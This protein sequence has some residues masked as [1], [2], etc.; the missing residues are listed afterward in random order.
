MRAWHL[1]PLVFCVFCESN[2]VPAPARTFDLGDVTNATFGGDGSLTVTRDGQ[3]L[4]STPAGVPLVSRSLDPEQPD[5]WHDPTNTNGFTFS[6]VDARAVH[7]DSPAPGV[8]H[9]TTNDD[10]SPTTLVR[11]T[12]ASDDGFYTGMG[13]RFSHVSARGAIVPMQLVVDAKFESATN[14]A[15]VPVPLLVSSNGYGVFFESRE[16][17]AFDVAKTDPKTVTVTFEG[18]SASVWFF[19]AR[20]PLH[21]VEMYTQHVGLPRAFPRWA[22]G[23]FYWRNKFDGQQQVIDDASMLRNLHIPTTTIWIDNPWQTAWNTFVPDPT[24]YPDFPTLAGVLTA[25]GY[26]FMFWS[27]PYLEKPGTGPDNEA[28]QLYAAHEDAF[29]RLKDDTIFQALGSDNSLGFGMIDFTTSTG[30]DFWASMATRDVSMGAAGFKLDYGEDIV[31]QFFNAR[32]GIKFADGETDR[33]ARSYPLGYHDA[34]HQ[35]L[36]AARTDGFLLVRASSYGGASHTDAIWPGDLDNDFSKYGDDNGSGTLLV[37]G[38]P[39]AVIAAQ[40]LS[41][42]G[43]PAFGSDTGGFRHGLPTKEALLRWAEHTAYSVVM[44]N[45]GGGDTHAPW[46]YDDETVSLYRNLAASHTQLEPYL[47]SLARAAET[48]GTPTIRALPLA[49][50]SDTAGFASAD[51]EY[52]LGPDLLVAPVVTQGAT[53]RTVHFPPGAWARLATTDLVNG[54]GDSVI[55]APLGVPL[56]YGRVGALVPMLA[57]DVDTL[58]SSSAPA[59]VTVD[60]R[61]TVEARG[62]PSGDALA[63]FDDG[64]NVSVHDAQD[65]VTVTFAT[66]ALSTAIVCTLDLR[67][68]QGKKD[69]LTHVMS[70]GVEL[71]SLASEADVRASSGSAYFLSGDFIVLRLAGDTSATIE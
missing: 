64:A 8:L 1:A 18:K 68:R 11:F 54:P 44:Q 63:S 32:I 27:E 3:T 30:R 36:D 51:D 57:A 28:R 61:P 34:Y 38:L 33:T 46:A 31:A 49:F 12:L 21:V 13:E 7:V 52:M 19:F 39:S 50:P 65:G 29:V 45:G 26:R 71:P 24:M 70:N 59:V 22:L 5:A 20:D 35:A 16:S 9:V 67:S 6:N 2:E 42:S 15:H 60:Q 56:V 43:F 25:L 58:V 66:N 23:P 48:V 47:S 53:S 62:W 55:D 10:G 4:L 37:G 14:D 40:T 41:A 17:G 69:P